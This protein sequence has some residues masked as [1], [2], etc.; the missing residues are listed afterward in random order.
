MCDDLIPLRPLP[1][2]KCVWLCRDVV[3]KT[4]GIHDKL[5]A[6]EEEFGQAQHICENIDHLQATSK[7]VVDSGCV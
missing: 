6:V 1:Y 3:Y 5:K 4:V 2:V 7:V